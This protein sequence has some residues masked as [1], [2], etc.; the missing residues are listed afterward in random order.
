MEKEKKNKLKSKGNKR[1]INFLQ[2]FF[3]LIIVF[4]GVYAAFIFSNHRLE[5]QKRAE[6]EKV[7]SLMKVGIERYEKLFNGIVS[8]HDEYNRNFE[9]KLK[10]GEIISY[11]NVVYAQPQYPIDVIDNVITKESYQVF[12]L[13]IYLPLVQFTNGVKRLMSVEENLERLAGEYEEIPNPSHPRYDEIKREQIK[14]AK[15]YLIFNRMRRNISLKLASAASQIG[16]K[17]EHIKGSETP[18]E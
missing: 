1:S 15:R 14:N 10:I 3:D 6:A 12:T 11:D 16:N 17:L 5:Q 18:S 13:D 9:E 7:M 2:L 8:Y 4:I